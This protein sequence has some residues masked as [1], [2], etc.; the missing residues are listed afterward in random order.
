MGNEC[1]V[2]VNSVDKSGQ[3]WSKSAQGPVSEL[4]NSVQNLT[5]AMPGCTA[6]DCRPNCPA[7]AGQ[8]LWLRIPRHAVGKACRAHLVAAILLCLVQGCIR[9]QDKG[10]AKLQ[11]GHA[12]WRTDTPRPRCR[13]AGVY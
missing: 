2:V 4:T 1:T 5:A 7:P 3:T 13:A 10:V 11:V 8:F 6:A 12:Q 9:R